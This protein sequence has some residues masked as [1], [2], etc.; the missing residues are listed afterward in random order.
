[1]MSPT[2]PSP[3]HRGNVEI[4]FVAS[5][6]LSTSSQCSIARFEVSPTETLPKFG[7]LQIPTETYAEERDPQA[8]P[9][10]ILISTI[11][12]I[13]HIIDSALNNAQ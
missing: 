6:L 2:D 9:T 10:P 1:M 5:S 3:K 13:P 8:K 11:L 4:S 7:E 12:S